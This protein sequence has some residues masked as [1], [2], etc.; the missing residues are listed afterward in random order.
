MINKEKTFIKYLFI[1]TTWVC[2]LP[3]LLMSVGFNFEVSICTI[4]NFES[5][6]LNSD[7][8]DRLHKNL[9]DSF[10]HALLEWT[11]FCFSFLTVILAWVHFRI[12]KDV[13]I[14]IIC[15]GLFFGGCM[16]AMHTFA[17]VRLIEIVS[18]NEN[19]VIFTW[20]VCRIFSGLIIFS[21]I[22]LWIFFGYKKRLKNTLF[23]H[24]FILFFTVTSLLIIYLCVFSPNLPNVIFQN[25][26]FHRPYDIVA[27]IIYISIIIIMISCKNKVK[28]DM[29]FIII[30]ISIIPQ[31]ATQIYMSFGSDKLFDSS[32]NIAHFTKIIAY[33]IPFVGLCQR[34]LSTYQNEKELKN[35]IEMIINNSPIMIFQK[36]LEGR[37]INYNPIFQ[38][39]FVLEGQTIINK[40]DL[41]IFPEEI[42][43][44]LFENDTYVINSGNVIKKEEEAIC[45][46]GIKRTYL[47]TKFP[48]RDVNSKIVGICGMAVEISE[49]K[50]T[51]ELLE[52]AYEE[53]T[54][55][56]KELD[57]FTYIVSHDLQ[58]PTRKIIAYGQILKKD[59]EEGK[60]DELDMYIDI[61]TNASIRMQNLV[62][63]LLSFSRIGKFQEEPGEFLIEDIVKDAISA[64]VLE[65]KESE[66]NI[67]INT[68]DI[69]I[70]T[71]RNI[72]KQVFIN[73]ISNAIKFKK[74]NSNL[75]IYI[76]AEKN[77]DGTCTIKIKDN[78]I[79]IEKQ[80]FQRIFEPF[81][82][83]YPISK[84]PGS[85]IGLAMC[86]KIIELGNGK[87]WVESEV[88]KG[89]TF[90]IKIDCLN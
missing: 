4:D 36:D 56:N 23:L 15:F 16:D 31:I 90:C 72:M 85:G 6:N 77:E 66:A 65:I 40:K 38:K 71:C 69:K 43:K 78:G 37:Y 32:F 61:M 53:L 70:L 89:S 42:A 7:L 41:E 47:S 76:S 29:F 55:K 45:V 14:L 73:L 21:G 57:E 27:L 30:L 48:V 74:E 46:D 62:Q 34:Y 28:Q 58:E 25:N 22:I 63:D 59:K 5:I 86:K 80:Y 88:D 84:Y 24:S 39:A 10:I 60:I 75:Y 44:M 33:F 18:S 79:G 83:L 1:I 81:K 11:A 13:A 35:K 54:K 9:A 17:S 20:S 49:I 52:K 12:K 50:N 8:Y 19:L 51:R 64:S 87:I 2:I 67:E 68:N 26:F 3:A 82:K